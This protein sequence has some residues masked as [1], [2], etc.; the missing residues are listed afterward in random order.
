[1]P[2]RNNFVLN[3]LQPDVL[4]RITS[5]LSLVELSH[6]QVLAESDQRIDKVYFPHSGII[7]CIVELRNGDAIETGM[8]GKDGAFG[9]G[10]AFDGR[11]PMNRAV[12]QAA[13]MAS[14]IASDRLVSIANEFPA[15]KNLLFDYEHFLLGRCSK[16]LPAT[17]LTTSRPARANGCCGCTSLPDPRFS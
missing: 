4:N 16:R 8:I 10:D 6:G 14:V 12:M 15:L 2:H 5:Q 13:G 7:S 9:A 17:Q 1:M 11:M 3:R